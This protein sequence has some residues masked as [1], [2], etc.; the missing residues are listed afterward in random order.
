MTLEEASAYPEALD[1]VRLLV[2]PERDLDPVY[3]RIWWLLWR[4]RPN[5]RRALE[6]LPRYVGGTATGK[7]ILFCWCDPWTLPSNAMNVFAFHEDYQI[8]VLMSRLH[9][10]W[11]RSQSSTLEDRIRYTPT[12]AFE[13]FPW[14][15][16]D[17]TSLEDVARRLY[18]RRSEICIERQIGLTKLYNEVDDGAHQD[19]AELQEA[20]DEAVAAAYGWPASAAHDSQE[21]NRLLLELNRAIAA[22]EIDYRPFD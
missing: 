10:E 5:M 2:K 4:P 3:E 14:P 15:S 12:S 7:R 16:G 9:T 11:A 13:T 21:S 8:G 19:L 17:R 6:G 18:A 1:A 22:G 20:L